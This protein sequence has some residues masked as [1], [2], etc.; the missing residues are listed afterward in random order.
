MKNWYFFSIGYIYKNTFLPYHKTGLPPSYFGLN[1]H[2]RL[3]FYHSHGDCRNKEKRDPIE[4]IL[5][6]VPWCLRGFSNW[7]GCLPEVPP[8]V[9]L[10]LAEDPVPLSGTGQTRPYR[11]NSASLRFYQRT[12]QC[13]VPTI[14]TLRLC[15]RF[16]YLR[17]ALCSMLFAHR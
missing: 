7:A 16:S 11:K 3:I 13:A 12:A 6:F 9:D 8:E 15:E 10:H 4:L 14:K 1:P 5:F 17:Y 2:L